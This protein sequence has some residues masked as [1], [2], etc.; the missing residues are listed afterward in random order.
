MKLVLGLA[1]LSCA[2]S[3]TQSDHD[4]VPG[5]PLH[6]SRLVAPAIV[7]KYLD[8]FHLE[9]HEQ[10]GATFCVYGRA[11]EH[12]IEISFRCDRS[13]RATMTE[14]LETARRGKL[15][16]FPGIGRAAVGDLDMGMLCFWDDDTPRYVQFLVGPP[17]PAGGAGNAA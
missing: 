8:G 4:V 15:A 6:C 10:D 9:Q 11:E 13:V 1:L 14:K 16:E 3:K 7:T 17:P 5:G 12:E 2:C